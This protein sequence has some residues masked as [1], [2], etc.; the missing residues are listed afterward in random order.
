M[1]NPGMQNTVSNDK[2]CSP[3]CQDQ[4]SAA[5]GMDNNNYYN[6]EDD[7][8]NDVRGN[9][10]SSTTFN[11]CQGNVLEPPEQMN[12]KAC[13]NDSKNVTHSNIYQ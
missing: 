2:T 4:S 3:L 7:G 9:R 13:C 5:G 6:N 11:Q 10:N 8:N 12:K 1:D